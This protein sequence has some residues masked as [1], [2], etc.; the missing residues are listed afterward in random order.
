MFKGL[1]GFI[2]GG[3]VFT[4]Q[5]NKLCKAY[6]KELSKEIDALLKTEKK[7]GRTKDL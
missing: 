4:E 5:G 2:I 1:L 3:L 6:F 7:N